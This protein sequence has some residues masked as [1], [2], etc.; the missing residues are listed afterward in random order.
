VPNLLPDK[1]KRRIALR[2][3]LD[4]LTYE[5]IGKN[6]NISRQRIQQLISPS[7]E[8]RD[9]IIS[10]FNGKCSNCGLIVGKHGHVHH[11]ENKN[12][13]EDYND[14]D[15]LELLCIS[16]HHTKHKLSPPKFCLQCGNLLLSH[17]G[18]YLRFCN[19]ECRKKYRMVSFRC[20]ECGKKIEIGRGNLNQRKRHSKSGFLFCSKSC[21]ME[22]QMSR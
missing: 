11:R 13:F 8:I 15:N 18:Y 6:L 21:R 5:E 12:G 14:T 16:C 3:R 17:N 22:W 20:H 1:E 7:P 9:I 4:G 19:L 2:L 10:R